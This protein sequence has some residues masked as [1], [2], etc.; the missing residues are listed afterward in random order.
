MS[1]YTITLE[2]PNGAKVRTVFSKRYFVVVFGEVT[3]EWNRK[4]QDYVSYDPPKKV[5]HVI[6]RTDSAL[7]AMTELRRHTNAVVFSVNTSPDGIVKNVVDRAT[8]SG[9]ANSEKAA[10]AADRRRGTQGE[11]RRLWY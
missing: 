9:R 2:A 3:R 10:K 6:K 8:L 11:A 4:A 5:A 7:A 1:R